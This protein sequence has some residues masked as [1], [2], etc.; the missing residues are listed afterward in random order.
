MRL[1]VCEQCRNTRDAV[2]PVCADFDHQSQGAAGPRLME[3]A[4][5]LGKYIDKIAQEKGLIE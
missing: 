1:F 2:C 4:E 3:A 5:T